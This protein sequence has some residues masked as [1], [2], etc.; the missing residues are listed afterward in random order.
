MN[1]GVDLKKDF[2]V[3]LNNYFIE[4]IKKEC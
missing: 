1:F 4:G 2:G 3:G